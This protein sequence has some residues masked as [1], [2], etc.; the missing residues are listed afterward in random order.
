MSLTD[1]RLFD[2]PWIYA[3]QTGCWGLD[4]AEIAQLREYL[5]SGGFLMVDDFWGP[6]PTSGKY[7]RKPWRGCSRISPSPTSPNPT[8]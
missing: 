3:T 5:F 1:E 8:P 7:S 2:Y 6:I 4:N